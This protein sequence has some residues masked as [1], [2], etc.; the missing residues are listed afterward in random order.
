MRK[1]VSIVLKSAQKCID[2][3]PP[4]LLSNTPLDN[5][6]VDRKTGCLLSANVSIICSAILSHSPCG[7]Y[8]LVEHHFFSDPGPKSDHCPAENLFT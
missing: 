5:G 6:L 4:P 3:F 2:D 1:K 7:L 8:S